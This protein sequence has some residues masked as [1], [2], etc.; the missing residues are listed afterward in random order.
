MNKHVLRVSFHS[1]HIVTLHTLI[2]LYL[3]KKKRL[4][5]ALIDYKKTFDCV[6]R[7]VLWQR[8]VQ[9]NVNG[10]LFRVTYNMYDAAKS[11]KKLGTNCQKYFIEILE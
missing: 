8:I 5:C 7:T 3:N 6:D 1:D 9:S 10:K 11:C 4:Y 2:D